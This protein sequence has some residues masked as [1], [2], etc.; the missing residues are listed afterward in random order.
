MIV[1][2]RNWVRTLSFDTSNAEDLVLL[3]EWIIRA[4]NSLKIS[5]ENSMEYK[6]A[7]KIKENIPNFLWSLF[8]T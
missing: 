7:I 4:N 1:T 5:D 3:K 6:I 8:T 2:F